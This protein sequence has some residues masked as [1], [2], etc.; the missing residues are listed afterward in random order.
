[1]I[2]K[3]YCTRLYF[4]KGWIKQCFSNIFV[5]IIDIEKESFF[6]LLAGKA[7]NVPD[8]SEDWKVDF[9]RP[10]EDIWELN[11]YMKISFNLL[12]NVKQT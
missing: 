6:F 8:L 2:E 11:I 5:Q 4:W 9:V 7:K 1:M 10:G 3:W 12:T